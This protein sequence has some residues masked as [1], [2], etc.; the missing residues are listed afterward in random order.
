RIEP[1]SQ[2]VGKTV[3]ESDIRRRTGVSLIAL[4]RHAGGAAVSPDANTLL[5]AGDQL[6]VIG[7]REQ[8]TAL[9]RLTGDLL[10][11]SRNEN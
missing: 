4:L 7:T 10:A 6:I 1:D 5:D 2:I 3:G 11:N 8:L 9:E